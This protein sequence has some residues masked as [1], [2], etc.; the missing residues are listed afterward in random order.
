MI[1]RLAAVGRRWIRGLRD[2]LRSQVQVAVEWRPGPHRLALRV[3]VILGVEAIGLWAMGQALPGLRV[4]DWGTA[5]AAIGIIAALNAIIRPILLYLA[6]SLTVLSFGLFTFLLNAALLLATAYL[7]PGLEVGGVGPALVAAVGLSLLNTLFT[8]VLAI[9]DEDSYFRNV[10]LRFARRSA[11]VTPT[12]RPGVVIIQIDGLALPVLRRAVQTGQ[13]PHV[14]RWLRGGSHRLIGWDCGLPSQTSA[15]QAGILHGTNHDIP[16]FRWYEK[17]AGRLRVSNH[18]EDAALIEERV[19]GPADLLRD[20]GSSIG[21]LV[22]GGAPH[23]VLMTSTLVELGSGIRRR[24][25]DFYLFLVNPYAVTRLVVMMV[26]E[27][28]VEL[29]EARRQRRRGVEP[30]V[31]RGGAFPVLRAVACVALRDLAASLVMEEMYRGVPITFA[32]LVGYDEIAH[33]AG[34]ERLEAL[35]S[36]EAIDRQIELLERAAVDAPRPYRFVILSDHGQSQGATFRQRYGM[37]LEAFVGSLVAG[38]PSV[39]AATESLEGWGHLNGFLSELVAGRGMTARAARR[40]LRHRMRGAVVE[41]GPARHVPEPAELVVCAS[42]NLG[43][44]YLAARPGRLTLEE[45]AALHPGLVEGLVAHPGIGFALVR[46]GPEG[47]LVLGRAGIRYLA[48]DRVEGVD[49]LDRFDPGAADHLRRLDTFPHVG[50]IVVNSLYEPATE[51]VA[52]FE[53]L[54]G[55]HGGL[56]GPQTRPF[57]LVPAGWAA[58]DGP[59]VGAP[60]VNAQLRRWIA[61][62]GA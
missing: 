54:V 29:N 47:A 20:G 40:S 36:L 10:V 27:M 2:L 1:D 35:G 55:S 58:G 31:E 3:A 5:I 59:I 57:L 44:I 60:A 38:E 42:G 53:E 4:R 49:P 21:N 34:P 33:H 17:E 30:R 8:A 51:E 16:A 19:S 13:M 7:L 45:I 26:R 23:A 14:G 18:P 37:T 62:L 12:D 28:L 25:K 15:S 24:S 48:D 22:S 43:L 52:A 9:D 46:S 32:D 6:I 39:R 61:A 56:G 41:L 11:G 50:D